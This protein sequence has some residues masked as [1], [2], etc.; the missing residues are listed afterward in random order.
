MEFSTLDVFTFLTTFSSLSLSF[1]L[2][3]S[4]SFSN[5]LVLKV[6]ESLY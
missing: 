1:S 3:L 6:L 4:L 2:S 5:M